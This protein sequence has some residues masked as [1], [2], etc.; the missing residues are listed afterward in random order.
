MLMTDEHVPAIEIVKEMI[1]K[2][3]RTV[4]IERV[5]YDSNKMEHKFHLSKDGY[6]FLCKSPD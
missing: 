1:E 3:D 4:K 2:I 5:K 6:L